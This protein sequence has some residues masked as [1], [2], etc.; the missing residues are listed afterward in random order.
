MLD[1][2]RSRLSYAKAMAT[3]SS[4][5]MG[6]AAGCV[7]ARA[8]ANRWG[9][10]V[11]RFTLRGSST[12]NGVGVKVAGAPAAQLHTPQFPLAQRH[13]TGTSGTRYG[14]QRRTHS[15][16]ITSVRSQAPPGQHRPLMA[17]VRRSASASARE[18]IHL[19][20]AAIRRSSECAPTTP[21]STA[22]R[23]DFR[24]ARSSAPHIEAPTTWPRYAVCG[25]RAMLSW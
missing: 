5:D 14:P 25:T 1:G 13:T 3:S 11:E 15:S 19:M 21:A 18:A 22:G 8:T 4:T 6:L 9:A 7:T 10:V 20:C 12:P 23:T 2:V 16:A 17:T 24:H